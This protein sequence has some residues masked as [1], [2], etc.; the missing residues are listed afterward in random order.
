MTR[1]N[2]NSELVERLKRTDYIESEKAEEAFRNVDRALFVPDQHKE[3]AYIDRP[4]PIGYGATISAPHMVAINT[5][6]LEVESDSN[7]LEIGSGSGYQLAILAELAEKV[8]GVEIIEKLAER[9]KEVL[10][11][12]NNAEVIYGEGLKAV[13]GEFDRILFSCSVDQSRVDEA[14]EKLADNGIILAP[15]RTSSGQVLKRFQNGEVEEHSRVR[16]VDYKESG[17]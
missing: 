16:F 9:S 2:S 15:V 13:G 11:N 5:E 1:L 17:N 6:F 8:V 3:N 4:L 10:E 12:W 7:V 14:R